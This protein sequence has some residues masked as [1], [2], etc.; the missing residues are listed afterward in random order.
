M[1][2]LHILINTEKQNVKCYL[3][4]DDSFKNLKLFK[5]IDDLSLKI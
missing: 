4:N 5:C 2:V 3:K 1:K